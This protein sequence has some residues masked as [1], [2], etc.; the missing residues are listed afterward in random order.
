MDLKTEVNL[1]FIYGTLLPAFDNP[2]S[3]WLQRNSEPISEG[4]MAGLLYK[5]SD[6]PGAVY[7]HNGVT[8]VF[9]L[10]L[11]MEDSKEVLTQLD[12]YENVNIENPQHGEY[13]RRLV[14]INGLDGL[15]RKCWVYLFNNDVI[16]LEIIKSGD[17]FTFYHCN[18]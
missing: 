18:F 15:R 8:K 3:K 11:K 13:I 6:Y 1:L 5:V 7:I 2:M 14:M 9:G 12:I 10:I 4:Y 16:N 17:Y